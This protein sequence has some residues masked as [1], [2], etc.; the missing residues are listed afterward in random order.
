[1]AEQKL[2]KLHYY[3]VFYKY[4][5]DFVTIHDNTTVKQQKTIKYNVIMKKYCHLIN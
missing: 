3:I 4:Y 1:M 5:K 2:K